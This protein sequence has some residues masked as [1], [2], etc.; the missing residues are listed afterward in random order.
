MDKKVKL[1]VHLIFV[2]SSYTKIKVQEMPR[3]R[4]PCEAELTHSDRLLM[5]P[6][7]ETKIRIMMCTKTS[8]D[9]Y[10][11]LCKLDLLGVIDIVRDD[12]AVYQDFKDRLRRSKVLVRNWI[13][14]K[15]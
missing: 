5:S 3:V 8:T 1:L 2:T 13:D 9:D 10:E 12:L 6:G 4:Q 7:K 14:V 15:R 11:N